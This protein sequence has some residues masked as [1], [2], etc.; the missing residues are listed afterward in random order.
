MYV[1]NVRAGLWRRNAIHSSMYAIANMHVR[2][3]ERESELETCRK[4]TMERE[5]E[6]DW[7]G[8][9]MYVFVWD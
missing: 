2:E 8:K 6:R 1:I 7:E 4:T 5:R 9:R 3:K